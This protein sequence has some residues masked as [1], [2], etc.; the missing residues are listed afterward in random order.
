M[1]IFN[2]KFHILSYCLRG[3]NLQTL[4]SKSETVLQGRFLLPSPALR[5]LCH[6]CQQFMDIHWEQFPVF[7]PVFTVS[8][9]RKTQNQANTPYLLFACRELCGVGLLDISCTQMHLF[10]VYL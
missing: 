4:L 5:S 8:H 7:F 2:G 9:V 3:K 10:Y 1:K 6:S